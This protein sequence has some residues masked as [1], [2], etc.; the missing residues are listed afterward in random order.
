VS[1]VRH[2][3]VSERADTDDADARKPD[4]F[5]I[6]RSECILPPR[7]CVFAYLDDNG[8][9]WIHASDAARYCDAEIRINGE[10]VADFVDRLTDLI[11]IPAVGRSAPAVAPAPAPTAKPRPKSNAERQRAHRQ[12]RN[13]R[14]GRNEAVTNRNEN[15]T[16][17][18]AETVTPVTG[19]ASQESVSPDPTLDWRSA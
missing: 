10:D 2:P 9:L 6:R 12:N 4:E 19:D 18:N 11:G 7:T 17:R 1:R 13:G 16:P 8:N 3:P 5:D 14:N 15:V